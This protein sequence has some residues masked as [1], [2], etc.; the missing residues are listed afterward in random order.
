MSENQ[1]AYSGDSRTRFSVANA[2]FEDGDDDHGYGDCIFLVIYSQP[3]HMRLSLF[4]LVLREKSHKP[5]K[6][7][8][9]AIPDRLGVIISYSHRRFWLV[10]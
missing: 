1:L 3:S 8:P 9:H 6:K 7:A 4:V 10:L 5:K 2:D